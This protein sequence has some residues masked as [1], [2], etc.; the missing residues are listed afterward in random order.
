MIEEIYLM[1]TINQHL[2]IANYPP[3]KIKQVCKGLKK[4][5]PRRAEQ[6]HRES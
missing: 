4:D 5:L 1:V 6:I 3:K 2:E